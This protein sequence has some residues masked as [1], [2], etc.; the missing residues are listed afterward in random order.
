MFAKSEKSG[1][2]MPG[3]NCFARGKGKLTLR[4]AAKRREEEERFLASLGMTA[5]VGRCEI[6][7][8]RVMDVI[9]R[10]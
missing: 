1:E 8:E 4:G 2:T 3:E 6:I 5:G 9:E 7:E 10:Q